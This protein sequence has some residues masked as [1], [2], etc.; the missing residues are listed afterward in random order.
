MLK[1]VWTTESDN[2]KQLEMLKQLR[3]SLNISEEV[4][5]KMEAEIKRE[6]N[7]TPVL[8]GNSEVMGNDMNVMIQEPEVE[9]I[10]PTIQE[11][12]PPPIPEPPEPEPAQ[13]QP[14][15]CVGLVYLKMKKNLT[16]GKEKYRKMEYEA[17]LKFFKQCEE[18]APDNEEIKFFLKKINLK[19][20]SNKNKEE[21]DNSS[22]TSNEATTPDSS[23]DLTPNHEPT[24]ASP[25]Q[26]TQ[27]TPTVTS[28][29]TAIP[30]TDSE[31]QE[32]SHSAPVAIPV[33]ETEPKKEEVGD[34]APKKELGLLDTDSECISCEGTGNCYWCN[35]TGNC[36]RCGGTGMFNDEPCTICSGSGKCNSCSGTG[37]C[38]WCKGTG[39]REKRRISLF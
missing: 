29:P 3:S 10:P 21:Q 39:N 15:V 31:T 36:D 1:N 27:P 32:S 7:Q 14:K 28:P 24:L 34:G 33:S 19:L 6:L 4:H 18:L 16:L 30:I 25:P 12:S 23:T 11:P 9:V 35:S 8:N 17:A 22:N 2:S 20:K 38:P 13:E 26:V 5:N 37:S